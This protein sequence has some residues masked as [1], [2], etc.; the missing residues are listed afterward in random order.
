MLHS[1][2]MSE[3]VTEEKVDAGSVEWIPATYSFGASSMSLKGRDFGL[4][5]TPATVAGCGIS[6][7]RDGWSAMSLVMASR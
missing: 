7:P 1:E 2:Y 4:I 3:T 6:P 5:T